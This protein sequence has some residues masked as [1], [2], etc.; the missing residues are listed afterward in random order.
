MRIKLDENVTPRAAEGLR[1]DGHDVDTALDEGLGGRCDADVW[2]A[3]Q[4][5]GRFVI[6][7]D[8]H[9]SDVRRFLPGTHHGI[10]LVRI[11]DA[12]QNRL[13]DY[14]R[15][16]LCAADREEW[17]RCFVVATPNK[18]RVLRPE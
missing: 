1:A 8:L 5:G 10:L 15:A 4:A 6:T 11:P 14:L 7:Q 13:P 3:A 16:W 12:E 18:V 9:F 2:M 17:A